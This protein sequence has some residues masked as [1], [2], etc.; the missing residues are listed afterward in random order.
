MKK[1][2]I[3]AIL[4]LTLSSCWKDA[5]QKDDITIKNISTQKSTFSSDFKPYKW[6]KIVEKVWAWMLLK[7]QECTVKG[8]T[9]TVNPSE[10]LP[11]FFI[12]IDSGSWFVAQ[13]LAI[14]KFDVG[15]FDNS[16]VAWEKLIKKFIQDAYIKEWQCSFKKITEKSKDVI[17]L[18]LLPNKETDTCWEYGYDSQEKNNYFLVF[19]NEKKVVFIREQ[20]KKRLFDPNSLQLTINEDKK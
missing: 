13:E 6:C 10:S 9:L 20:T 5:L 2:W 17:L 19:K 11:W 7:V 4:I 16:L 18:H 15:D 3:I 12:E 14:Q 1:R 8:N